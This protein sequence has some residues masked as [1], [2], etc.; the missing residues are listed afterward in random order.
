MH[1][2]V[3]GYQDAIL[4]T[5]NSSFCCCVPR[6]RLGTI[7][8]ASIKVSVQH[9][10]ISYHISHFNNSVSRVD[11]SWMQ[12]TC[13]SSMPAWLWSSLLYLAQIAT[14]FSLDGETQAETWDQQYIYI[15]LL[16]FVILD[17]FKNGWENLGGSYWVAITMTIDEGDGMS[18]WYSGMPPFYLAPLLFLRGCHQSEESTICRQ[19]MQ[20]RTAGRQDGRL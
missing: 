5:Q 6:L 2:C 19:P 7:L 1:Q 14:A 16:A 12:I 15:H 11:R 3:A 13:S 18:V 9:T 17:V 10:N 8:N 4:P 20:G